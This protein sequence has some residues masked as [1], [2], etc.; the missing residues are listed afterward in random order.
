M[1]LNHHSRH[2]KYLRTSSPTAVVCCYP[3]D[4]YGYCNLGLPEGFLDPFSV[5]FL[6]SYA[7][8]HNRIAGQFLYNE[9]RVVCHHISFLQ[10]CIGHMLELYACEHCCYHRSRH[11][12]PS[13]ILSVFY[14]PASC[15]C[16]RSGNSRA[17]AFVWVCYAESGDV[18]DPNSCGHSCG[19]SVKALSIASSRLYSTALSNH[20]E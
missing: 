5:L 9:H 4:C 13:L 19:E 11:S 18:P 15:Y 16:L 8:E 20:F 7:L 3:R 2:K 1:L 12:I 10:R 17:V 6:F 14:R